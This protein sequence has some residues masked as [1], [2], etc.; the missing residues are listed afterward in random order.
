MLGGRW[1]LGILSLGVM[2]DWQREGPANFASW[3]E[4]GWL[5]MLEEARADTKLLTVMTPG[6]ETTAWIGVVEVEGRAEVANS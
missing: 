6:D 3:A 5:L 2:G 4:T 1:I